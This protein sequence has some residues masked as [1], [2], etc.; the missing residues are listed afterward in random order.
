MMLPTTVTMPLMTMTRFRGV[1]QS[2]FGEK[3]EAVEACATAP[4]KA[5][6]RKGGSVRRSPFPLQSKCSQQVRYGETPV[7]DG[8]TTID[9]SPKHIVRYYHEEAYLSWVRPLLDPAWRGSE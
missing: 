1:S 7:A 5:A 8:E 4:L 2:S 9:N 6:R 3:I